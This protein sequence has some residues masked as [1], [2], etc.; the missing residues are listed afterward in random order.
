MIE[1]RFRFFEVDEERR[2][3]ILSRIARAVEE[4]DGVLLAI[5]F[6]SFVEAK[7][8]RDIDVALY[9]K[10]VEGDDL[11]LSWRLSDELSKRIGYPID[12]KIL[13]NAPPEIRAKILERGLVIYAKNPRLAE[14]LRIASI[15]EAWDIKTKLAKNA[16]GIHSPNWLSP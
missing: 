14:A 11:E 15:R 1:N 8:F 3:E 12:V 13:N 2:R 7:Y 6:G 5:V 9:L 16:R 10:H 4:I